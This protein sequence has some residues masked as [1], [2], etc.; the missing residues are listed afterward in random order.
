MEIALL[1]KG[2]LAVQVPVRKFCRQRT[3]APGESRVRFQGA[4][5][6]IDP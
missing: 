4:E 5:L 1:D 2:G 6:A 3:L